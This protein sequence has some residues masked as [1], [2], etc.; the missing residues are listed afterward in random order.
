MVVC[1]V[2]IE[3]ED[4]PK[5]IEWGVRDSKL[6]SPRRRQELASQIRTLAKHVVVMR[7]PAAKIDEYRLRGVKLNQIEAMRMAEIIDMIG[8][9]EVYVDAP[10]INPPRF[11]QML[12]G[13]VKKKDVKMVV[14]NYADQKYPVVAAASIVGK[15]VR[16][17][18]IRQIEAKV[19]RPV[20]V[21]YS[22]DPLTIE[23]VQELIRKRKRLPPYV[24]RTWIT[25]RELREKLAR[26]TIREFIPKEK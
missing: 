11:E 17:E 3:A 4:E 16:D 8:P 2:A 21:G 23:F 19:G 20:G 15:V 24:R 6:I 25:T 13:Y 14:E 5:L 10:G 7:V 22:H 12:R 9:D 18:A 26:R 1:G